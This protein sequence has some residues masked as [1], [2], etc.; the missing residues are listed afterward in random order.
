MKVLRTVYQEADG[1]PYQTI[2][3]AE[4]WQLLL[5]DGKAFMNDVTAI[6]H[7]VEKLIND[8]FRLT[9]DYML[10]AAL[11]SLKEDDHIL[12]V[13]LHHIASDGWSRSLLVN[14]FAAFYRAFEEGQ[15]A[16]LPELACAICRFCRSG[17]G[18]T[19]MEHCWQ[20]RL[21]TGNLNWMVWQLYNCL[22]TFRVLPYNPQRVPC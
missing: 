16:G 10:R 19:W 1:Q 14:N 4:G 12:V 17:S 13:T 18:A 20:I 3:D 5:V 2:K 22:L 11:I 15:Q 8:P 6:Q 21:L 7:Y 9:S